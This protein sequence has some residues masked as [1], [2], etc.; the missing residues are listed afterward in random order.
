MLWD[1]PVFVKEIRSRMRLRQARPVR[2][3]VT[4]LVGLFVIWAYDQAIRALLA[5]YTPS[6][7]RDAFLMAFVLQSVLVWGTCPAS[8]ANAISQE[9][10]Q[11]TWDLLVC[12]LLRPYEIIVGKLVARLAP[13]L[14]VFVLFAPFQ[15]LCWG[16]GARDLS[17]GTM[18][19]S[20]AFLGISA[21]FLVT[22]GLF[23]SFTLRRTPV[24]IACAYVVVAVLVIG[25][26]LITQ[27]VAGAM[28][29]AMSE[30][31]LMWI[32]PARI[33]SAV[34]DPQDAYASSVLLVGG[35]FY[36]LVTI[37]LFWRMLSRFRTF[38][39]Q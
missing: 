32:N 20:Y 26:P 17:I 31:A 28:P 14:G 34:C 12:S 35:L 7:M 33:A 11:Q 3:T 2:L 6:T 36:V 21:I 4:V 38:A 22:V 8:A 1:N 19:A 37:F 25:T 27:A 23:A 16:M 39:V 18:A 24:A 30:F 15:I 5:S 29:N 10:E 9:R 13:A